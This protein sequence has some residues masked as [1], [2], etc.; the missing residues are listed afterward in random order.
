MDPADFIASGTAILYTIHVG[1]MVEHRARQ[2]HDAWGESPVL[3]NLAL[4]FLLFAAGYF[5]WSGVA[6]AFLG[7]Y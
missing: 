7:T 4:G 6:K 2:I 1:D 3:E 5:W